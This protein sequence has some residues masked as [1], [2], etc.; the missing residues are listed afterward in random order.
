MTVRTSPR[1]DEVWLFMSLNPATKHSNQAH[2]WLMYSFRYSYNIPKVREKAE[3]NH[4]SIKTHQTNVCSRKVPSVSELCR[5]AP[6][7]RLFN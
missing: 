2:S 4:R 3:T 6:I 7:T 1:V 5:I